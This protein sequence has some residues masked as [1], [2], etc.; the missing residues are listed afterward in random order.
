VH[1]ANNSCVFGTGSPFGE[2]ECGDFY[3]RAMSSWS[4]LLAFQGFIYDGPKQ[5]IGFK[6]T[7]QPEDHASFFTTSKAWGLF[8]QTQTQ[9]LQMA[10][11]EV[12]FGTAQIKHIVLATPDNNTGSKISVKLDGIEQVIENSMQDGNTITIHLKS[13]CEV[14]A[15]STLT[16]Y[17]GLH[18]Q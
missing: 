11:I 7:W 8:T 10:D 12:K 13:A 14:E 2:D 16:V 9:S 15:G 17:F 5:A 6:P 18:K 1:L 3:T 4:A